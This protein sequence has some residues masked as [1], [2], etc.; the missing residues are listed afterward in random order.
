MAFC[1]TSDA[2]NMGNEQ[3]YQRCFDGTKDLIEQY[4][5]EVVYQLN[6]ISVEDETSFALEDK[7][8]MFA[9]IRQSFGRS[10]LLLSGGGGLGVYHLGVLRVLLQHR[11]LPRVISGSSVGSLVAAV[12]CVTPDDELEQLLQ[13]DTPA[14]K[15]TCV[16]CQP[17][18]SPCLSPS[19]LACRHLITR[20]NEPGHL[21]AKLQHFFKSVALP[22]PVARTP[23]IQTPAESPTCTTNDAACLQQPHAGRCRS[24]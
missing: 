2:G 14:L 17:Y 21:F 20:A 13:G 10:A 9:S 6:Y 24:A 23:C 15:S 12:V 19:V 5:D 18:Y 16:S 22:L 3:L 8:Q 4:V 11:L 1:L 7:I